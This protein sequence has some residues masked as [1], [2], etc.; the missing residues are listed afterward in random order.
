MT[1]VTVKFDFSQL[2]L[3]K[4]ILISIDLL[5]SLS[6]K[7]LPDALTYFSAQEMIFIKRVIGICQLLL[8]GNLLKACKI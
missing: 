1:F 8:F 2:L 7:K 4:I 5:I 6:I 3:E